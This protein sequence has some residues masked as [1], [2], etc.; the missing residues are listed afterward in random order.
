MFRKIFKTVISLTR[1]K[2][3]FCG[4][5]RFGSV[6]I[7]LSRNTMWS[8]R[9]SIVV[10][11]SQSYIVAR[12]RRSSG[13]KSSRDHT[14]S[15]ESLETSA[16]DSR[17]RPADRSLRR[18]VE[19]V[20][21]SYASIGLPGPRRNTPW[22]RDEADLGSRLLTEVGE[23]FFSSHAL[24]LLRLIFDDVFATSH[25]VDMSTLNWKS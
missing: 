11:R 13:D 14:P 17:S 6:R 23:H 18:V 5:N 24:L 8:L 2:Y 21:R 4:L 12:V 19:D 3:T 7:D 9:W 10:A 22:S 20:H 1:D 16:R 15:H 25:G